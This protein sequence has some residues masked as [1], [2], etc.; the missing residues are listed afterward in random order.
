[1]NGLSLLMRLWN[2]I[3]VDRWYLLFAI[4]LS[5]VVAYLSLLQPYLLKE[6]I[7]NHISQGTTD[8]VFALAVQYFL[9]ALGAY[10]LSV[11]Y[12]LIIAWTGRRT[13]VR[14]RMFLFKRVLRLPLSFFDTRPAGMLLTRLTNDIEALGESI[15]AGI[16]TLLLDVLLIIGCLGMMFYLDVS[17][18]LL[19]LTC[20]PIL[21]FAI[22]FLRRKLRHFY[23]EIRTATS[24]LTAYLAEQIDGV[25][26]IQLFSAEERAEKTFED[27]NRR[28]RNA[29]TR[30]NIYDAVMFAVVDGMSSIFIA[31]LLWYAS[32]L[33]GNVFPMFA[34]D[35]PRTLGLM[36]AFIDYLNRLLEPIK[37]L[38][39][40]IAVLQ[41][42]LAALTKV[43]GLVD[44]QDPISFEGKKPQSLS[45][46]IV[47]SDVRFRYS[48]DGP[49]VIK[50][51]SFA[52]NPGEVVAIVGSSGSGKTT[53]SR[54]LDRS[55]TGYRGSITI[56]GAE[57]REIALP[58]L[59][60]FISAVRQDIQ[61]FSE[62]IQFNIDLDNSDISEKE[63]SAAI[64]ATY[65]NRFVDR[66]GLHHRLSEN[67]GDLSVG[68]G[69]LLTFARMMAHTPQI[70]ILD[71]AT[72]SIDSI[73]ESL[74][75]DA[76]GRILEEKTVIVIAHRLSTIQRADRIIV[77]EKGEIIEQ[78]KHQELLEQNGRY[79]HLVNAAH[80]I[81]SKTKTHN[82]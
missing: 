59:R 56:N 73:T 3:K 71:E 29:C 34:I 76:I 55:Y 42:A 16:V 50:G 81:F 28:F 24:K 19:L 13:L 12:A 8:G 40:K 22:E 5:P 6:I 68:E 65:S 41:R 54:L 58:H 10:I 77:L 53:I 2:F 30:S 9:A 51:I 46:S 36:V 48:D 70:V 33:M 1:M 39:S 23:L 25:E 79:A 26:I 4:F 20:S 43:F 45:G 17:L 60:Q 52:V 38:S 72:A 64:E 47:L 18:S 63:R 57:L 75:Q 62:T 32:S 15:S 11:V 66:L 80:E 7:D 27:K 67:G 37:Q 21:I 31:L 14:L 82:S 78:G 35:E 74:I 61:I 69:Q 44:E 49:D